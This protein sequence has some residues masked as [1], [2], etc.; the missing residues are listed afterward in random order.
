MLPGLKHPEKLELSAN[1]GDYQQEASRL[2]HF[3]L[4]QD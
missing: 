2:T 3:T 1:K 4:P